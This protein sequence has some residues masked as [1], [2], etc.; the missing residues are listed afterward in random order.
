MSRWLEIL[1]I[2][3]LLS[4]CANLTAPDDDTSLSKTASSER[5]HL[6]LAT[7]Q[8]LSENLWF[9][10]YQSVEELDASDGDRHKYMLLDFRFNSEPDAEQ[11]YSSVT[12]ICYSIYQNAPL[13]QDLSRLGYDEVAVTFND[14][15]HFDCI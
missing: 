8:D 10:G 14:E 11:V 15:H 2:V 9:V 1:L 6:A 4:G 7:L 12:S 5:V 13:M 3:V